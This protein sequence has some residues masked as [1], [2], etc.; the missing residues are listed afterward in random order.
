MTSLQIDNDVTMN[1]DLDPE[2]RN[3]IWTHLIQKLENYYT[4]TEDVKAA[5]Y[6]ERSEVLKSLTTDF[7]HPKTTKAVID[8]VIN[9]LSKYAVH[10]PHPRYYGMFN[11]RANFPSIVADAIT[12]TFNPQLA[13]WGHAPYAVEV[14]HLLIQEIGKKFGYTQNIDGVFTTGGQEANLTAVLAALNHKF[15]EYA[16]KGMY[17]IKNP[18]V[19]YCSEASHH[20][21]IKAAR[22]CGLGAES[23]KY[24]PVDDKQQ[25]IPET[26]EKQ[27]QRDIKAGK[28][29]LMIMATMGT[30]G[31]GAIDP[32]NALAEIASTYTLWLHADAAYGGAVVLTESHK[33]LLN[34]I[35]KV[36]S[37][38]FDAHKWLSVPMA[39]SMFIT[40]HT[41]ILGKTFSISA[42]FMPQE[43]DEIDRLGSYTHSIQWSRRF[44]GLKLYMPL[45][46][47]GWEGYDETITHQI[48]MGTLLKEKLKANNWEVYNDTELPIACF[49]DI[50]FK[51]NASFTKYIYE[52]FLETGESWI[53]NY[54][55]GNIHTL[56][57]CITNYATNET[58]LD[59]LIA[60]LNE[61]RSTYIKANPSG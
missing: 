44:I 33:H 15:P 3:E 18:P 54:P 8:H 43:E 5:V 57:A 21:I 11:P 4:N 40:K 39:T 49:N 7:D 47:F 24:I 6:P 31:S 22:V 61:K 36:D 53:I 60:L 29:P 38:T 52:S 13:A 23:V 16:K 55:V 17:A 59:T 30:T 28:T 42:N 12:A 46:V 20:A 51:N 50:C 26:T 37:I 45:L 14:E 27:I 56:R 25:M 35:E 34:G 10:T 1:F 32:V 48:R 41:Y 19:I 9:G 58:H 2:A